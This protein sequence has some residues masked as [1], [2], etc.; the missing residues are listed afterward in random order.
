MYAV[1]KEKLAIGDSG[2]IPAEFSTLSF[3]WTIP[4]LYMKQI[5]EESWMEQNLR[6]NLY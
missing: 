2:V 4:S 3:R 5:L 1:Y 6:N